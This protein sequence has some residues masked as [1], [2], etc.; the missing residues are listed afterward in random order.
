[1]RAVGLVRTLTPIGWLAAALLSAGAL[2]LIGQGVGLRW[3]PFGLG[4]RRL[5]VAQAQA[6]AATADAAA[7]RLEVEGAAAQARRAEQYHQQ[8]AVAERVT[9]VAAAHAR[10][11]H[12]ASTPLDP[13][14]AARLAGHDREL[15]RLA[16]AVCTAPAAGSAH[17]G[18]DALRP[19]A[20]A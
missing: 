19:A 13:D 8:S 12:D 11:A 18:D 2:F 15:C 16:P 17:G 20:P 6:V 9:A 14:R 4:E 10:N 1:V 7:R 5:R 3:D